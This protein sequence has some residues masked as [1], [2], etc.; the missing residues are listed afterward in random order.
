MSP[1]ICLD[2]WVH[3]VCVFTGSS[4][5]SVALICPNKFV[6]IVDSSLSVCLQAVVLVLPCLGSRWL[7][8]GYLFLAYA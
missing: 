8:D 7:R 6:Q 1:Y 2:L 4:G 5:P 3:C